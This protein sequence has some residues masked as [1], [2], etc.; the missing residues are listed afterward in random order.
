MYQNVCERVIG[1]T[2]VETRYYF[3]PTSRSGRR[4]QEEQEE[5][6]D[7]NYRRGTMGR[8]HEKITY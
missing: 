8:M 5:E 2:I 4:E 3:I 6:Y 1:H 7:E